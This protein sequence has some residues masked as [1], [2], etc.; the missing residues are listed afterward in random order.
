M[1][2]YEVSQGPEPLATSRFFRAESPGQ[3][4]AK[5]AILIPLC[6]WALVT[7]P[8]YSLTLYVRDYQTRERTK[9]TFAAT[10]EAATVEVVQ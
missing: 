3:A 9:H 6:D 2:D 5:R 7:G 4:A 10:V 8:L 1:R